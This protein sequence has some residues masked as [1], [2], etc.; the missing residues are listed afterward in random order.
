MTGNGR[1]PKT[2]YLQALQ[3]NSH[4]KAEAHHWYASDFL[5]P[6]GRLDEALHHI[7]LSQFLDPLSHLTN[8]SLGF[9]RIARREYDEAIEHFRQCL[10]IEPDYY[11]FH[12]FL[13]RAFRA[14][15]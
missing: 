11:H 13:G 12:T 14:E 3:T 9:V 1:R 6:L 5:A 15:G 4:S 7:Q 8:S 2:H 10:E